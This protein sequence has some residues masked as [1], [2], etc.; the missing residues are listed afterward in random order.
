MSFLQNQGLVHGTA[1][2]QIIIR[3]RLI[4]QF[5][6]VRLPQPPHSKSSCI[7]SD[8]R[9]FLISRIPVGAAICRQRAHSMR[10]YRISPQLRMDMHKVYAPIA[11]RAAGGQ[12]TGTA[13]C[14]G[15]AA[16]RAVCGADSPEACPY[17]FQGGFLISV[18]TGVPDCPV[19]AGADLPSVLQWSQHR[20][21]GYHLRGGAFHATAALSCPGL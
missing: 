20:Y 18:G 3:F 11:S 19:G 17:G 12:S 8:A 9:A 15:T 5:S 13:Q 14:T 4:G 7:C 10:P 1:E 16:D 21:Y 6:P 2:A